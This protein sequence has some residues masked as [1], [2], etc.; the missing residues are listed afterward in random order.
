MSQPE[1]TEAAAAALANSIL[2]EGAAKFGGTIVE[3]REFAEPVAAPE[4]VTRQPVSSQPTAADAASVGAA[5]V[6]EHAADLKH[7]ASE[8]EPV[9]SFDPVPDDELDALL[10]EPDIAAEVEAE[11]AAEMEEFSD[12]YDPD[13]ARRIKTLEKRNQWLEQQHVAGQRKNWVA[14]NLR[15]YPLLATYAPDD[16]AAIDATSRRAFAREAQKLNERYSRVLGPALQ[17]LHAAKEIAKTEAE[18][19]A[20]SKAAA[21]WGLP[22]LDPSSALPGAAAQEAALIAARAARAPLKER[23]KILAGLRNPMQ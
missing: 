3:D 10:A 4:P 22:A 15:K 5:I 23:I 11:I 17:D 8:P 13:E 6:D 21:E 20:R 12:T 9:I 16:I 2:A 7:L 1:T 18:Q 14:E 19:A